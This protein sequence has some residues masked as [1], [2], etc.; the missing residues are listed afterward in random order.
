MIHLQRMLCELISR[1]WDWF[2]L[3][4]TRL[5]IPVARALSLPRQHFY[6]SFHYHMDKD[7]FFQLSH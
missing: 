7:R 4:A 2:L 5:A 3:A 6:T 1:Y